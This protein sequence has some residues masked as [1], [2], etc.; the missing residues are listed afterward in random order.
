MQNNA[1]RALFD[2]LPQFTINTIVLYPLIIWLIS[3]GLWISRLHLLLVCVLLCQQHTLSERA[4]PCRWINPPTARWLVAA[5][6]NHRLRLRP[7]IQAD[8]EAAVFSIISGRLIWMYTWHQRG[9]RY[10]PL[11]SCRYP[12]LMSSCL[13]LWKE[14]EWVISK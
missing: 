5:P 9:L 3:L 14:G 4:W 8:Y 13:P 2:L 7:V 1:E 10:F 12:R 6:V 11:F